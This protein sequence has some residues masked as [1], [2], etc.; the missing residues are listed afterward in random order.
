MALKHNNLSLQHND[1]TLRHNNSALQHKADG[2]RHNATEGSSGNV[3]I[4]EQAVGSTWRGLYGV[5]PSGASITPNEYVDGTTQV[6]DIYTWAAFSPSTYYIIFREDG[7]TT[8]GQPDGWT[9]IVTKWG[10]GT[11]LETYTLTWNAS[12]SWYEGSTG[13]ADLWAYLGGLGNLANYEIEIVS[14]S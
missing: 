3:F 12:F 13:G 14:G 5:N 11:P 9:S 10:P 6:W 7:T 1:E 4:M 2:L 8:S